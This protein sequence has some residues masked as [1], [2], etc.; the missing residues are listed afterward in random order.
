MRDRYHRQRILPQ[1]GDSGQQRLADASIVL[2][3]CGALGP[4]LAE[5][6]ARAGVGR[7]VLADRD[8]VEL[9]NLQRQTL[10]TEADAA[11][12]RPKAVAAAER[13]GAVNS[14]V[15]IEPRPIDVDSGNVEKLISGATLVL[16][17]TDN[18]ATR[19]LLND[20]CVKRGIP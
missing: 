5:A 2:I 16:D 6:L 1:L 11:E 20:A 15:I 19:Y 4:V 17:G 10:Y 8:L 13:L 18:A 14:S 7:I 3:G 9:T 12:S